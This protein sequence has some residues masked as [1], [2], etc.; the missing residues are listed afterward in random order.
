MVAGFARARQ[1]CEH[2]QPD[3]PGGT[4]LDDVT[5]MT[6]SQVGRWYQ[7]FKGMLAYAI[8][9]AGEADLLYA[10]AKSNHELA[11]KISMA[12]QSDISDKTPAWKVEA[13]IADDQK[14]MK[15]RVE[16]QKKQAYK[17]AMHVQVKSLEHKAELFSR[18]ITR[19]EQEAEQ[20]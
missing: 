6:S 2:E 13:I 1:I 8:V 19:R 9:E 15:A 11:K 5:Q 7:Y 3:E 12:R 4:P 10:T 18:E 20:S 17:E 14:Y 16:L